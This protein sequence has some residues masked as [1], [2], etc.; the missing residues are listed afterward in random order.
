MEIDEHLAITAEVCGAEIS[1]AAARIMMSDLSAY[2]TEA[3]HAA[4]V[5]VRREWKG[6]LSLAAIIE[7]IDDGRPNSDEAWAMVPTDER[8]T[9]VLSDEI[10]KALGACQ[11]LIDSGDMIA[12]RMAFKGA[13]ERIVSGNKARG[14]LPKWNVSLGWDESGREEPIRR[15]IECGRISQKDG[16][17][18]IPM[19]PVTLQIT[20]K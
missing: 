15:A 18:M 17:A 14:I 9:A 4:L 19:E 11:G 13:Y 3:V 6:R 8:D 5:R 2:P 12:A 7:R 10:Q 20:K 1:E 16:L